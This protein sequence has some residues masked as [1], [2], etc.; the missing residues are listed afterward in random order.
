MPSN[1]GFVVN[2]LLSCLLLTLL[3]SVGCTQRG[4][5]R[6]PLAVNPVDVP[7]SKLRATD[8]VVVITDASLTMVKSDTFRDAKALTQTLVRAMPEKSAPAR[9]PG[10]YQVELVAFGGRD[11]TKSPL[12]DFDRASLASDADGMTALGSRTPLHRVLNEAALSL[13]GKGGRAALVI[14]SDGLP[15]DEDKAVASAQYLQKV[16]GGEVCFH[17]VQTG[18]D[19]E[20]TD[21]M[22]RL[23]ALSPGCGS[24]RLASEIDSASSFNN[25]TADIFLA[26]APALPPVGAAPCSARIVLRGINFDFDSNQIRPE[27][28]VIL[29][30]AIDQLAACPDFPFSIE[31]YTDAIGPE[32]YNEGLSSRRADAVREYLIN[33]GVEESRLE[34]L[35]RGESDPVGDNATRDGRAQNRRVTLSPMH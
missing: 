15:D 29:D 5:A 7:P 20:G 28:A 9:N 18:T 21:F 2:R 24:S 11:R 4:P 17:T 32:S 34:T 3:A 35:G 27:D 8:Q 13:Q 16:H 10:D 14:F 25:L 6:S 12:S 1:G 22:K 33:G 23:S 19:P 26:D 31:G 30:A